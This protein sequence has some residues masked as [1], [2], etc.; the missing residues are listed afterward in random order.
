MVEICQS[1]IKILTDFFP[2][3]RCSCSENS[4]NADAL[5]HIKNAF[6]T[7]ECLG[8]LYLGLHFVEKYRDE[9]V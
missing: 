2:L 7:S 6:I 5:Y 1:R 8:I 4:R 9:R 3:K